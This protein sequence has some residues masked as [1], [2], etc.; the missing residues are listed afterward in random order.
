MSKKITNVCNDDFGGI[1]TIEIMEFPLLFE[2]LCFMYGKPNPRRFADE[3]DLIYRVAI[4]TTAK[5]YRIAHGIQRGENIRKYLTNEQVE[6]IDLIALN[7]VGLLLSCPHYIQRKIYL[8]WV[9]FKRQEE[10]NEEE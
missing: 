1:S 4:G 9:K 2:T 6:L 10:R 5:Q 7:D 8:E 3:C